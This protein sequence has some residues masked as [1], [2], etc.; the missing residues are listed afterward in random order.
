MIKKIFLTTLS[1]FILLSVSCEDKSVTISDNNTINNN[2]TT[3]NNSNDTDNDIN[4][5]KIIKQNIWRYEE[6]E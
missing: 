5:S 4:K 2:I 6:D 1:L 3:T